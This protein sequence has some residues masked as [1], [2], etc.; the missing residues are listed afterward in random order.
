MITIGV[1]GGIAAYK[2]ID[3]ASTLKKLGHDIQIV[4]TKNATNFVS[5]LSFASIVK[6]PVISDMFLDDKN[7]EILHIELAKKSDLLLIAPATANFIGKL[8]AGIADDFLST[9]VLACKKPI[10][11]AP[12]MNSN[13]YSNTIV[14]EN[15]AYLKSKGFIFIEPD[16]GLLACGDVGIGKLPSPE[17][18]VRLVVN[19][20][21]SR[22]IKQD[23]IGK[24]YLITAGPTIEA[25][26][27]MR[28]ISNYS[29]GKMGYAL[30][31]MAQK[32]GANVILISGPTNLIAPAGVTKIDV[33]SA[34]DMYHAVLKYFDQ[35]DVVI[36]SAAVADFRPKHFSDQKIKKGD[37]TFILEL[38]KNPDILK[39]LGDTKKRQILVGFAAESTDLIANAQTKL[40]SKNLDLIVANN[41]TND[42]AGFG[43]TTNIVTIIDK[44]G[45][46]D[47]IPKMSKDDL[48]N[49]ILD[50]TIA[51]SID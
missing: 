5:P 15:I 22:K 1:T 4:M 24:T 3:V 34:M 13:M 37:D 19:T 38:V 20:I 27:P 42:G 31:E 18:I 25:L 40:K 21:N 2:T 48:A 11:I 47:Q 16:V 45:N 49:I 7:G 33:K 46:I 10:I 23:L 41:I 35:S 26:D 17:T 30:S 44:N 9:L 29:T 14:T 8:R 6:H 28:Y 50:K 32:R 39:T 36:K 43:L 12:A 51:M